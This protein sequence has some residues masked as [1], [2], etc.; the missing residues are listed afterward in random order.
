MTDRPHVLLLGGTSETAPLALKLVAARCRVLV[1]TATDATLNV[2]E[3]SDIRRRCGRLN[4]IQL[5]ELMRLEQVAAIIDATHPYASEV[6]QA[7]QNAATATQ[8]PYLRYQRQALLDAI[9]AI[10]TNGVNDIS[11]NPGWIHAT[12]H[13]HAAAIATQLA[14]ESKRGILLTTGSR[15]LAPY[16]TAAQRDQVRLFARVLDH[17]D[18][19]AACDQAGLPV[20]RRITGRGPFTLEQNRTLI[21][22]HQIGILVTKDSGRAGGVAEKL[23][24]ARLERCQLIVVQRPETDALNVFDDMD[25]LIK[26]LQRHFD[27]VQ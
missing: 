5:E 24:A 18:S 13:T 4:A 12:D 2:G 22:Q 25:Q 20:S 14:K 11:Y 1:S 10:E 16:V 17:S 23:E 3:H 8:L 15:H 19:S 7:A 6:Q 26:T 9:D 27:A 21:Q